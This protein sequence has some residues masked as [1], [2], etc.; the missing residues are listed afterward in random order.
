MSIQTTPFLHLPQWTAE[1][2]PSFLG[3]INQA[4]KAIDNGYGDIK[5]NAET[6]LTAANN[7]VN[8]AN[9]SKTQSQANAGQ[10]TRLQQSLQQLMADFNS[11]ATLHV[12]TPAVEISAEY[13][14]MFDE[15]VCS[16]IYNKYTCFLTLGMSIKRNLS[17]TLP[18]NYNFGT[19]NLPFI[20][21]TLY[22]NTD[23]PFHNSELKFGNVNTSNIIPCAIN[24]GVISM[25][26]TESLSPV[27]SQDKIA[28][29]VRA[30]FPIFQ[31]GT[32][33]SIPD[34]CLIL[35]E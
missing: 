31:G 7:A 14:G 28:I 32:R 3:E 26:L 2:Q 17:F 10:I 13:T 5:T 6:A 23:M 33:S 34:N 27:T 4:W 30:A 1:E 8:I 11:A 25:L 24:N 16:I 19:V 29:D 9:A 35:K 21:N 20:Y 18:S 12:D 22:L 15:I